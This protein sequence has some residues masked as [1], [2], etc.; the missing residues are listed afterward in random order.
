MSPHPSPNPHS[1]GQVISTVRAL[2]RAEGLNVPLSAI[3]RNCGTTR[4][5]LY[6]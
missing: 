4:N 5:F 6:L 3:A 1:T 2:L